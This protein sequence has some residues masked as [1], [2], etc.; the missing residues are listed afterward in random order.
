[1]AIKQM[2]H[3][4]DLGFIESPTGGAQSHK[5]AKRPFELFNTK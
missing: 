4:W 2:S 3:P 1:M 5:E